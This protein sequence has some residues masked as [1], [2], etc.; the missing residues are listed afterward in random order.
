MGIHIDKRRKNQFAVR[1]MVFGKRR[2]FGA[3]ATR[4]EA[5][6]VLQGVLRRYKRAQGATLENYKTPFIKTRKRSGWIK[7]SVKKLERNFNAVFRRFR[8]G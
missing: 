1:V 7:S 6:E 2:S 3:Y 8:R 5:E 4:E